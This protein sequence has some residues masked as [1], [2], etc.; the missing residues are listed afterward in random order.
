MVP[1]AKD[2][3]LIN[4]HAIHIKS[5]IFGESI[6]IRTDERNVD[7]LKMKIEVPTRTLLQ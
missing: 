1:I 7:V 3:S 4:N 2:G 5:W 6:K